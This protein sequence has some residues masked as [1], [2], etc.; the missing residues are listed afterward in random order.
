[1]WNLYDDLI[2]EIPTQIKVSDVSKTDHWTFVVSE[3]AVGTAMR[4]NPCE[5]ILEPYRN[6][7]LQDAA[8]FI[9]SWDFEKASFGLAAINSYFNEKQ[10][11]NETFSSEMIR[12]KDAFDQLLEEPNQ[13]KIGMIGHFP[14]ADR[15]PELRE[16]ISI[17]ELEPR[18]GDYPASACE[19]LLPQMELVFITGSTLVNKTLPRLLELS[20]NAKTVLVGSSCPL[21]NCLFNHGID[22]LAGTIY[23][24]SLKKL[25]AK[26]ET[27]GL[28]LS[29]YGESIM[30]EKRKGVEK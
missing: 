28:P 15:Y 10:K 13:K 18:K 3:N 23:N 20:K 14:F 4:F 17:F 6:I 5:T 11:M 21:S 29:K 24:D 9:K 27:N 12:F 30:I 2:E 25:K 16:T 8:T 1:M 22:T 19:F 7:Q 26:K